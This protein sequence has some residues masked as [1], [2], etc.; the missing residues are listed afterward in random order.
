MEWGSRVGIKRTI[1]QFVLRFDITRDSLSWLAR[2]HCPILMYHRFGEGSREISAQ[3]FACQLDVI[4]HSF[5]VL[6]LVEFCRQRREGRTD[7]RKCCVITVDDGYRDFYQIAYPALRERRLPATLFVTTGFLN[8]EIW[9]WWD[10]IDYLVSTTALSSA[11]LECGG[12]E[13]HLDLTTP[14]G[15]KSGWDAVASLCTRINNSDKQLILNRLAETLHVSVPQVPT[16]RYA[17]CSVEELKEMAEHEISFGPHSVN[18]P[19]LSRCE[20]D[21]WKREI[22]DSRRH[23]SARAKGYVDVF[24]YPSGT[25]EDYNKGMEAFIESAGFDAAV[26]AHCDDFLNESQFCLRRCS[27]SRD[28][29]DFL[30]TL[31]GGEYLRCRLSEPLKVMMRGLKHALFPRGKHAPSMNGSG[32]DRKTNAKGFK[33]ATLL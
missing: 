18:H 33:D 21:E 14:Q 12:K 26:A 20:P 32:E 29:V 2:R 5:N 8:R 19:V 7:W 11:T 23:L 27:P 25:K 3:T 31:N 30:W 16:E 1:K 24:A 9:L 15:R 13:I 6:P 28:L 10:V 17:S 4:K 22:S